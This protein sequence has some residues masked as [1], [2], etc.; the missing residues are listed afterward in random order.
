MGTEDSS[1]GDDVVSFPAY[2]SSAPGLVTWQMAYNGIVLGIPTPYGITSVDGL[3]LPPVQ[4]G[5]QQRPREH[6]EFIGL[7][8]M[9]GRDITVTGDFTDNPPLTLQVV[10]LALAE[11]VWNWTWGG[12]TE[13]PLWFQWPNLPT[14]CSMV[15]VRKRNVP[16][17]LQ[18]TLGLA[19]YSLNFHATDP[20]LYAQTKQV[21]TGPVGGHV[22][23]ATPLTINYLGN[24]DMRPQITITGPINQPTVSNGSWGLYA[25]I[26]LTAGQTLTIDLDLHTVIVSGVGYDRAVVQSTSIWPSY[27]N[28][29]PGLYYGGAPNVITCISTDGS[30]PAGSSLTVTYS[31]AYL[32]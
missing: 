14:L 19:D 18:Y 8:L 15:R 13:L 26:N 23:A 3:D 31:D 20:R 24:V 17:S 25:D 30:P 29:V 22:G 7:D 5:D 16:T 2:G 12:S 21:T 4:T 9:G 10:G 1:V 6:G 28:G 11:A 32:I 27:T